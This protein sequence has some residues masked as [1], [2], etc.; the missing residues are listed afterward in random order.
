VQLYDWISQGNYVHKLESPI[1]EQFV[2]ETK[3]SIIPVRAEMFQ[4]YSTYL[5]PYGI[6]TAGGY[7]P[8]YMRRYYEFWSTIL[9]P[10]IETEPDPSLMKIFKEWPYLRPTRL[11]LT[12]YTHKSER[13]FNDLY[14]LNL[15]SMANVAWIFSRDK[16]SDPE[17]KLVHG[18]FKPWSALT[19]YEKIMTNLR[20][21]FF[22]MEHLFVYKNPMVMP[23]FISPSQIKVFDNGQIVLS[24]MAQST[25][26]ELSDTLFIAK[27]DLPKT[28]NP[29]ARYSKITI[30]PTLYENNIIKLA[31]NANEDGLLMGFNAWSPFWSVEIDGKPGQIFPANH[32]FWGV[33]IPAGT[34]KVIFRYK[35]S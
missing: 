33:E 28:L 15:L 27:A 20:A 16:F 22:G 30:T 13:R 24:A 23:R 35:R 3:K 7:E 18:G 29:N 8:L 12:T 10:W 19:Q 26:N 31:V 9:E 2:A 6:E 1:I 32:A 4:M 25:V 14:R 5:H 17:L 21:N 11:F 34:H